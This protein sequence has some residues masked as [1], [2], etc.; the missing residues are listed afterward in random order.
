LEIPIDFSLDVIGRNVR[1]ALRKGR[2]G[3]KSSKQKK[4]LDAANFR[5]SF[6][7]FASLRP[8]RERGRQKA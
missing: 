5:F 1:S 6:V 7:F 4:N 3:A 2:K 8:L